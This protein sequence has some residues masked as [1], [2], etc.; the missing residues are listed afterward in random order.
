MDSSTSLAEGRGRVLEMP[1]RAPHTH[2]TWSRLDDFKNKSTLKTTAL[3]PQE[4]KAPKL[5][6]Y[7][8]GPWS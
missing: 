7:P 4:L 8:T 5:A 2:L 3:S 6:L 1:G